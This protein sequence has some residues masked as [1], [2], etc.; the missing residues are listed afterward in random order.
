MALLEK[1]GKLA[2]AKTSAGSKTLDRIFVDKTSHFHILR[3]SDTL[4]VGGGKM[5]A[6]GNTRQEST[7][8]SQSSADMED[9]SK[10][11]QVMVENVISAIAP[12]ELQKGYKL[13]RVSQANRAFPKDG[14]PTLGFV[15][16]GLYSA[17][18]HSGITLGPLVGELVAYEVK[19]KLDEEESCNNNGFQ[20]LDTYR[21]SKSRME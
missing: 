16:Q 5:V 13:E 15:E 17:V 4:V 8:E 2:Y 1:P 9:D 3:R 20:I 6:G 18:T 7:T 11:G 12:Y 19:S 21:P 14:F 10:I